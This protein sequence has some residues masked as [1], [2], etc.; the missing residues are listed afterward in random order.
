[1]LF[2]IRLKHV[3]HVDI[4]ILDFSAVYFKQR[5]RRLFNQAARFTIEGFAGFS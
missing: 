3:V 1:M 4:Q 2:V 5:K